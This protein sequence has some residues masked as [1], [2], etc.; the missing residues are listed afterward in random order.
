[1]RENMVFPFVDNRHDSP[2]SCA[3]SHL[4]RCC[5]RYWVTL[6][7]TSTVVACTSAFLKIA[8]THSPSSE[9]VTT[10]HQDARGL[11]VGFLIYLALVGQ[12]PVRG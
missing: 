10:S 9:V 1:M 12:L 8:S 3:P 11:C 6:P 7:H 4:T 2:V 5:F